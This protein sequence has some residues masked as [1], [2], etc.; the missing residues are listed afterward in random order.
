MNEEQQEEYQ[1]DVNEDYLNEMVDSTES[2]IE[3]QAQLEQAEEQEK[4]VAQEETQIQEELDDP[5][6]AENWGFKAYAKEA[7]SILTGGIQDTAS[8][9]ATFPERTKD[10]LSGEMQREKEEKGYYEPEWQPLKAILIQ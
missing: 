4:E 3:S 5:R 2:A 6:A 8:S 10:A 1:Y 9:I 7:Q